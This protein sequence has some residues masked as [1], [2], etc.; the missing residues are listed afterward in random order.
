M[1]RWIP[2]SWRASLSFGSSS[3]HSWRARFLPFLESD[4]HT[5]GQM[6]GGLV[7]FCTLVYRPSTHSQPGSGCGRNK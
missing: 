4:Y 3:I 6:L 1:Y 7:V 2:A 5:S